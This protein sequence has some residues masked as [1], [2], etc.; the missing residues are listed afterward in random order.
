MGSFAPTRSRS[1]LCRSR[2]SFAPRSSRNTI[3]TATCTRAP[4]LRGGSHRGRHTPSSPTDVRRYVAACSS[5]SWKSRGG[6]CPSFGVLRRWVLRW[7]LAL[8]GGALFSWEDLARCSTR[9]LPSG[10]LCTRELAPCFARWR[11]V[12][13]RGLVA[14]LNPG[15]CLAGSVAPA[16]PCFAWW[17][18]AL[19]WRAGRAAHPGPCPSGKLCSRAP[20][21]LGHRQGGGTSS[22]R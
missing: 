7:H 9:A 15:L 3:K 6:L 17:R 11:L 20:S 22:N 21:G 2:G 12:L 10:K 13:V 18:L 5:R 4:A 14:L 16:S 19:T 1:K 8:Q